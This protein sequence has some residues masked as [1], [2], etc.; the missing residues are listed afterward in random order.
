MHES[1]LETPRW[2]QY[3]EGSSNNTQ[4]FDSKN[5]SIVKMRKFY[6]VWF[7]W[8]L[9]TYNS[10]TDC[11]MQVDGITRAEYKNFKFYK[12]GKRFLEF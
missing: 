10:W 11:K 6:N 7:G 9:G 2:F 1:K 3:E 8:R 12:K 5:S 4:L